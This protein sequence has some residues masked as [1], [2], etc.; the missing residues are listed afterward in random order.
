[1]NRRTLLTTSLGASLAIILGTQVGAQTMDEQTQASFDTVMAFM[2]AMGSGNMD[3]M[4]ALMADDMVWHNEGDESLPWIGETRGKENIF[5][6]LGVFSENLQTTKW[7]NTDAFASG[8]TVA[9]FGVMNGITTHSGKETGDFSFALR[10]KVHD[11]Q[12][13]LWHWFEDSFAISQAYHG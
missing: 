4:G 3:A 13:V 10:A 9:V 8:D 1:M 11:G 6:F 2:G 5:A 12:V 7:E